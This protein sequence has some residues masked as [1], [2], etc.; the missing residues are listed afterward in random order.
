MQ[1]NTC[2]KK[3]RLEQREIKECVKPSILVVGNVSPTQN[4]QELN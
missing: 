1:K 2:Q 4:L 3:K